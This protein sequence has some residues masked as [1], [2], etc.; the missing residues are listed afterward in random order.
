MPFGLKNVVQT[1]QILMDTVCQGLSGVFI[2]LDDILIASPTREQ[3]QRDLEALFVKWQD[4][5]LAVNIDKCSFKRSAI[6][7]L[8]HQVTAEGVNPLPDKV[9]NIVNYATPDTVAK[10]Q[11]YLGMFN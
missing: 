5:G 8:G 2:Y 10:F 6:D 3:H 7:F 11:R 4:I 1:F 9:S